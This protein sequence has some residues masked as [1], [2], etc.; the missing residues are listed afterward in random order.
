MNKKII[1]FKSLNN[2]IRALV[3]KI[4]KHIINISDYEPNTY[5]IL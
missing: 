1:Y 4:Q 5:V 2:I 3:C